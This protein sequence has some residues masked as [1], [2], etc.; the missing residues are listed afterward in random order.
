MRFQGKVFQ[1]LI[2]NGKIKT[3]LATML[4]QE[5]K[6]AILKS[7]FEKM[8]HTEKISSFW[9]DFK[10]FLSLSHFKGLYIEQKW[11]DGIKKFNVR[12][13]RFIL[14]L[15]YFYAF[16]FIVSNVRQYFA[17]AYIATFFFDSRFKSKSYYQKFYLVRHGLQF[18]FLCV[19]LSQNNANFA[20]S[21]QLRKAKLSNS[22]LT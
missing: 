22:K 4:T 11:G 5:M 15:V 20:A 2:S 9:A 17:Q 1:E 14:P 13:K 8:C 18:F 3:S 6:N 12:E 10:I 19:N 7:F 16:R 21:N